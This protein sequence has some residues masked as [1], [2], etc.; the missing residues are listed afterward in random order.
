MLASI[1]A[2]TFSADPRIRTAGSRPAADRAIRGGSWNNNAARLRSANRNHNDAGNR[3][4]NLGLRVASPP[5]V[6]AGR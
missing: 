1:F 6:R 2:L 3:N 5:V 4:N